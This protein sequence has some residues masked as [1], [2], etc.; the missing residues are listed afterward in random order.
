MPSLEKIVLNVN[1]KDHSVKAER[2]GM[3][4][5]VLRNDLDLKGP[6]FGCGLSECGACTVIM[7]G[8]A[9]RS[10]VTPLLAA[11]G[12]K[13]VT[14]EGLGTKE[15]PGPMQQ[16]FIDEQAGQCSYCI[17]GMIM[18]AT[19][20]LAKN[21]NPSRDDIKAALNPNLC[22]CG[23]HMR[24]VRAVQRAAKAQQNKAGGQG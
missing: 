5:Y 12:H 2:S 20:F 15:N 19:A 8:E 4:L 13:I 1:G 3:L 9:T 23:T 6:K 22:R 18:L 7:D 10:C 24:I 16:A 11:E 21:P 14:L 17:N